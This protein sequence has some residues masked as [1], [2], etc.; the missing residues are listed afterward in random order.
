MA[1]NIL[2]I[3]QD[4][5][6]ELSLV[7]P[8]A[9]LSTDDETERRLSRILHRTVTDLHARF[10]WQVL[11]R[12]KTFTTLAADEQTSA[13]ATDFLRF[14]PGTMHNRTTTWATY[15][16]SP[17]EWQYQKARTTSA[18]V[19]TQVRRYGETKTSLWMYPNPPASESIAYEYI[20]NTL[21]WT[22]DGTTELTTEDR[23]ENDTDLPFL[24][25]ELITRGVVW[26]Y[27]KSEG[28]DYSEE[29]RGFE[30]YLFNLLKAETPHKP[31]QMHGN[32]EQRPHKL[33]IPDTWPG[34]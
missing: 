8:D 24:S 15:A 6:D 26:A 23:F 7:R 9:V 28:L 30:D 14:V 2:Q 4:A 17:Q 31:L 29:F 20:V 21:G 25:S 3:C 34:L 32:K 27:R 13:V 12:E 22:S 10:D 1:R 16:L 19:T 18:A 5:A 11:L 33:G